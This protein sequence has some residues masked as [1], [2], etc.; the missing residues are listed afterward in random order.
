MNRM[1][2]NGMGW[3]VR[4]VIA[5]LA[6]WVAVADARV[7]PA[8][9]T[10]IDGVSRPMLVGQPTASRWT[11]TDLAALLMMILGAAVPFLPMDRRPG[12]KSEVSN[13]GNDS[14]PG[15]IQ[16]ALPNPP[17]SVGGISGLPSRDWAVRTGPKS[18][19]CGAVGVRVA[20]GMT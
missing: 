18:N 15:S 13:P 5:V 2:S 3:G 12:M 7:T 17:R 16:C 14:T 11:P 6:V 10:A 20:R 1:R 19:S 8:P 4:L 9:T